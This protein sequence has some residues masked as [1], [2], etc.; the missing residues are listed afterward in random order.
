MAGDLI[1]DQSIRVR[2]AKIEENQKKLA[3]ALK[4]AAEYIADEW[5]EEIA[6][7]GTVICGVEF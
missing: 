7:P 1:N 2:V 4:K 5:G 3:E 6:E